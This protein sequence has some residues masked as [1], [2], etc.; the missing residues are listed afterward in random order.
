MKLVDAKPVRRRRPN[1]Y[2]LPIIDEFCGMNVKSMKVDFE[3]AEFRDPATC[4]RAFYNAFTTYGKHY[5][6]KVRMY[7]LEVFLERTDM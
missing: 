1:G 6:V 5:P 3:A 2:L 7:N 4:Y